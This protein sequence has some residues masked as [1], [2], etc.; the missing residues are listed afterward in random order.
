MLSESFQLLI[1][2]FLG[3]KNMVYHAEMQEC[4]PHFIASLS[5]YIITSL[6]GSLIFI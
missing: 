1:Y 4:L 2:L 5:E 6:I 3:K